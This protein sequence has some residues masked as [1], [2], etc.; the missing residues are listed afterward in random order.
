MAADE[1]TSQNEAARKH[2]LG[3]IRR[4]AEEA[5]MKRLEDEDKSRIRHDLS[6]SLNK[7]QPAPFQAV[8]P[9]TPAASNR[10]AIE[11]KLLVIRERLTSALERGKA[12]KAAEFLEELLRL[13][14]DDADVPK[15]R[16]RLVEVHAA[17]S[18]PKEVTRP[19]EVRA[20]GGGEKRPEKKAEEKVEREARR[21]KIADMLD[22]GNALYQQE[23]YDRAA[24]YIAEVLNLDPLNEEANRLHTAID[25]ARLLDRQIQEE[26]EKRRAK[27]RGRTSAR[28][29]TPPK[30]AE[31]EAR[32]TDFWGASLGG[33]LSG[34]KLESDYDLLPEEKGP[35]GPPPLPLG[36]R[37]AKRVSEVEIPVK[38]ILTVAVVV[39]LGVAAWYIYDAI[40]NS[41]APALYSILILPASTGGDSSLSYISDGF[42][43]ELIGDLSL[44]PETRVIGPSTAFAFGASSAEPGRIA[45]ALG[46]N[47]FLTWAVA[48]D[49]D[50]I[51]IRLSFADTATGRPVW[52]QRVRIHPR[53]LSSLQEDILRSMAGAMKIKL[54]AADGASLAHVVSGNEAAYDMYLR[55]RSLLRRGERFSPDEAIALFDGALRLDSTFLEAYSALAWAHMLSYETSAA[56]QQSH[57]AMTLG[58]VERGLTQG[59]RNSEIFRAWGLAEQFRGQYEKAQERFEQAVSMAPSDAEAQRRLALI[60]AARGQIDAGIKAAQRSV[61]DDPGNIAAHMM[62]GQLFQFRALHTADDRDDYRAALRAYEQGMRLARDKS[63]FGSGLYA[64]VLIHLQQSENAL[65]ILTDRVAR[66]RESYVDYYKLG[67]IQQ[68]AGRPIPEWQASFVR[69]RELLTVRLAAE[70]GDAVAQGYLA[71]VHTRLGAFRDAVAAMNQAQA[72][73]P[74]DTD[75]LY[76]AARMY[77]LQKDKAHAQEALGRALSRRYSLSGVLDLDFYNL[78]SEPEFLALL[79]R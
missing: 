69:A 47:Y 59:L 60:L 55:G 29:L 39:I 14:P 72:L 43:E 8:Q 20:P 32:P 6:S 23:K 63:E 44:V 76:L 37:I 38:P 68:S 19:P 16:A 15:Y 66:E 35:V 13:A 11:Q 53:E 56:M 40:R 64:D 45:R 27:E 49:S 73:A 74:K 17:A 50:R 42:T 30:A 34:A 57:I 7:S 41:V 31:P 77:A 58:S 12:D 51:G 78:Y 48:R 21:K 4:R 36:E 22:A 9:E 67:R 46:A 25:K 61:T 79:T 10:A 3:E 24:Q 65:T 70:P 18:R 52:S 28:M 75:V 1:S 71:L 5:E 54:V 62:L 26:E 33:P 2:L